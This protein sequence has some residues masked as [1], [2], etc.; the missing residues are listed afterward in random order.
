[1]PLFTRKPSAQ[2]LLEQAMDEAATRAA[3]STN[4]LVTTWVP[5]ASF[6]GAGFAVTLLQQGGCR[7]LSRTMTEH[8][9]ARMLGVIAAAM[10]NFFMSNAS[11][12]ATV[13]AFGYQRNEDFERDVLD[14]FD[15]YGSTFLTVTRAKA[16]DS[17]SEATSWS[18]AIY[19]YIFIAVQAPEENRVFSSGG[20]AIIPGHKEASRDFSEPFIAWHLFGQIYKKEFIPQLSAALAAEATKPHRYLRR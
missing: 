9:A 4:R 3:S 16:I 11:N 8:G 20:E 1:M 15:S 13:Q 10:L 12:L 7:A 2:R 19:E 5:I 17:D 14:C 6:I 18:F